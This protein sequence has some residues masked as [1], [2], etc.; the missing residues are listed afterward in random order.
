ME[1]F[2]VGVVAR[3]PL[4][5]AVL[6]S[7]A[8]LTEES[9]LDSVYEKYRGRSYEGVLGFETM[10][11]LTTDALLEHDGSGH[12]AI[13][14][15]QA[16]DQLPASMEAWYGKLRRIPQSLSQG[17]L[18]EGTQRLLGVLPVTTSPVPKSLRQFDATIIDGKK[19]KNAAKR[20]LP[21]RQFRGSV[22]GGKALVAL[23]ALG[24][25]RT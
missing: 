14:H 13:L 8:Y 2:N 15:A 24:F 12:R 20:L 7:F 21:T 18:F 1:E 11:N 25:Q 4:A 9:F 23:E 19:I 17:F 10:V 3:L 22:L 5:E 6:Q 16:N